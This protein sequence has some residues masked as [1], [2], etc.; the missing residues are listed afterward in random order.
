[1]KCSNCGTMLEDNAMFCSNCGNAVKKEEQVNVINDNVSDNLKNDLYNSSNNNLNDNIYNNA[2]DSFSNDTYN[3]MSNNISNDSSNSNRTNNNL[4]NALIILL[5]CLI[6]GGGAAFAYF[7]LF[8]KGGS[9]DDVKV[10]ESAINNMTDVDSMSFGLNVDMQMESEG[11][12][13]DVVMGVK[14][15]IDIKNKL[16]SLNINASTDGMTFDIPTYINMTSGSEMFYLKNPMTN[17]WAKMSFTDMIDTSSSSSNQKV[18]FVFE[19]YLKDDANFIEKVSNNDKNIIQ[20]KLHFTK[21]ILEKMMADENNNVDLESL[22]ESGLEDGF[23]MDLYINKKDNYI[24]KVVVDLSGRIISGEKVNKFIMTLDITNVNSIN[25]IVIPEEAKNAVD[26]DMNSLL[27]GTGFPEVN[28]PATPIPDVV[29]PTVPNPNVTGNDD[30]KL[31]EYNYE[32]DFILPEG[33]EASSVNDESFKIYRKNGMRVIM[34]IDYDSKAEFF[35]GVNSEKES[36]IND[37]CTD[38][39]LSEVKEL[40]HNDKTFYYQVIEYTDK[41]GNKN[42]EAYLCYELD[43]EHVYAVTYEDEDNVGS[44]TESSMRDFL[45]ITVINK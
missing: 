24:T 15:D 7:T 6:L 20:Y 45:N 29:T 22:K 41:Y 10:I 5:V 23:D 2:S 37:G 9:S 39:T 28:D 25:N 32:V 12:L 43:A 26:F 14:S 40:I 34:S 17:E 21:E 44:V 19:D 16:A 38:V 8:K 18:R 42:Y 27:G 1:M 3:N 31:V 30:Y 36:Y 35:E 33:Y 13:V 11:E 4:K